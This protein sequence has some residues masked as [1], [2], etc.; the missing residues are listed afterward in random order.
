MAMRGAAPTAVCPRCGAESPPTDEP[1]AHCATCK[2]AFDPQHE[3]VERP[4]RALTKGVAVPGG[5]TIERNDD[6]YVVRW[7]FDKLR[8]FTALALGVI[9]A[10]VLIQNLS[11]PDE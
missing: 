2:L 7:S 10:V 8:G 4:R 6:A 3:H 1:L 5:L 11:T 9:C